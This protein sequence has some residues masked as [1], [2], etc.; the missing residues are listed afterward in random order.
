MNGKLVDKVNVDNGKAQ[1][2]SNDANIIEKETLDQ[3]DAGALGVVA[4]NS[5]TT[6][7]GT[8]SSALSSE[9]PA[10]STA[11]SVKTTILEEGNKLE[12]GGTNC[13]T[14]GEN[15]DDDDT[16]WDEYHKNF[17][18]T[19][20]SYMRLLYAMPHTRRYFMARSFPK[21]RDRKRS[22]CR[23]SQCQ[24]EHGHGE[25]T[26]NGVGSQCG[27]TLKRLCCAGDG[28]SGH[29]KKQKLV[30]S[31]ELGDGDGANGSK[32][33]GFGS[34]HISVLRE[35]LQSNGTC[36]AGESGLRATDEAR[37]GD[38]G[39]IELNERTN[40]V[41][42]AKEGFGL[43]NGCTEAYKK[44]ESTVVR[45]LRTEKDLGLD[46]Y[47]K[48]AV[49]AGKNSLYSQSNGLYDFEGKFKAF[50]FYCHC[51]ISTI[52]HIS[53]CDIHL[54]HAWD[55]ALTFASYIDVT[56]YGASVVGVVLMVELICMCSTSMG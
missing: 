9:N 36:Q 19:P 10:V 4:G 23:K 28:N 51:D 24:V 37:N 41:S 53:S 20:Q 50:N 18:N 30:N 52:F 17:I 54:W 47:S 31:R 45:G 56:S 46:R 13:S 26:T 2:L 16:D 21:Q 1:S 33:N 5:E 38:Y 25:V 7:N 22:A 34:E 39:I 11:A 14:S 40:E 27:K 32:L 8:E 6:S 35:R 55:F 15:V 48:A 44:A 3:M 49:P 29:P 42:G 12:N 43:L